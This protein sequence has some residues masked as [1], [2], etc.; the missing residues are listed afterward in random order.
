[1]K[2]KILIIEDDPMIQI[3]LKN[4]LTGNGY[5]VEAVTDF[6][7]P[8]EHFRV[9]APHLV[10]LDIKLPGSSGFEICTQIRAFSDL[11]IIFVT[12]SNTDMDEL[13]S[14]MLGGDAFITK[15]YNPAIL[16]AK[17]A[18]L[19]RKAGASSQAAEVLIWNGAELH[20]ES[21]TIAYD[22]EEVELTKNEVKVLYYQTVLLILGVWILVLT[23]YLAACYISRKKRLDMLLEMAG[24]LEERYLIP[25]VMPV[26]D[27]AEEQVFYQLLKM[28][29]KSMLERIGQVERERGEYRA[30]IE[31]WVHEVKTPITA[32]KLLCENNRSPFSREVLAELE[33]I[34]R[35]AEQALYYA[36][37]EHTEK[38][39][40]IREMNLADVVHGAIADNKYLLRQCDMAIMVDGLELVVYA[41]DKWVRF[42]LDQ[43]VSNAVKYRAPQQPA[44]H[45][46]AERADDRVL[47]SIADNGVG[48]PES[49]LPRIFEKGFTGQNGRTIHSS[50][51]IG[52]YLCKRLCDKLGIG[53][54]ASS[55]GRGTTITL[56]FHI[57]DFITGV[58]G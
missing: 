43:I 50:T 34:N 25:E 8:V 30:Y 47:L 10:L 33:N 17:I 12:S 55:T 6:T 52:L 37:S 29:E 49:D 56:S 9:F 23:L 28:A 21:S 51:G 2:E 57:N 44:L 41:D 1:M 53:L 31:Q 40:S 26:P 5:E 36:R 15:P 14:I 48:I 35:C 7:N 19:L 22:G 45:I 11:P 13:N 18:S 38:D 27:R 54:A 32:L 3:Q 16:L 46:S 58:Q 39:Y 42:I 20:L 4:L 24:Q